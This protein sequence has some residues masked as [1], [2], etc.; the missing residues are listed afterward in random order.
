MK[1]HNRT[2]L[3]RRAL[4]VAFE[5]TAGILMV[6]TLMLFVCYIGLDRAQEWVG[7]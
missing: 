3:T 1:P 5:V 4:G 7:E 2:S 6:P